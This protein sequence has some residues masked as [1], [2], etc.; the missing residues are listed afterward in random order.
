MRLL[1]TLF[2]ALTVSSA[3]G[4]IINTNTSTTSGT[5]MNAQRGTTNNTGVNASQTDTN[6]TDVNRPTFGNQ[7]PNTGTTSGNV[8]TDTIGTSQSSTQR[9]VTP[10]NSTS[11]AVTP[12]TGCLDRGGNTVYQNDSGYSACVNSTGSRPV[13]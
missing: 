3:Q 6:R 8:R 5:S 7:V 11:P 10:A 13:R 12:T 2:L 9:A 4:Q 1:A